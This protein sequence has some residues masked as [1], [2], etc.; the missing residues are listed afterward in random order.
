MSAITQAILSR[1]A[2]KSPFAATIFS[3]AH[4]NP[5]ATV[6]DVSLP[7]ETKLL[8]LDE[9]MDSVTSSPPATEASPTDNLTTA[10]SPVSYGLR[11]TPE[12]PAQ[13]A[14]QPAEVLPSGLAEVEKSGEVPPEV[15]EYMNRVE[16]H[17]ETLPQEIVIQGDKMTVQSTQAPVM[18]VIVL[19]ISPDDE[20]K[21]KGKNHTFSISWL[22]EWSHKIIKMFLGKVIYRPAEQLA[23]D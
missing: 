7:D 2:Q 5:T 12:R 6:D 1:L 15:A 14:T 20:V 10:Q 11:R 19:P 23:Q 22:I 4:I 16:D 3:S 17:A 13:S 21:A 8:I 9:V 18:P